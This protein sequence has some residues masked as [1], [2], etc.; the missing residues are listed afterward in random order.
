MGKITR[1]SANEDCLWNEKI[2]MVPNRKPSYGSDVT[3]DLPDEIPGNMTG[4]VGVWLEREKE[5]TAFT[6]PNCKELASL[7]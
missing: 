5:K 2:E 4:L 3:N 6:F 7:S 1:K